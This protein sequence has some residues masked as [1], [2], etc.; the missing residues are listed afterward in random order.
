MLGKPVGFDQV[1]TVD[2]GHGVLHLNHRIALADES[3]PA[4]TPSPSRQLRDDG[5]SGVR[6]PPATPNQFL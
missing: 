6:F 1:L 4:L 3:M 5:F 2:K